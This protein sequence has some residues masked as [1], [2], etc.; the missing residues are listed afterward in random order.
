M[1]GVQL[2][3]L[4]LLWFYVLLNTVS[5]WRPVTSAW[6]KVCVGIVVSRFSTISVRK[7][8]HFC[9]QKS[10]DPQF[11]Q[12]MTKSYI[13]DLQVDW[14]LLDSEAKQKDC[15]CLFVPSGCFQQHT[16]FN[17][18]L[19]QIQWEQYGRRFKYT[20]GLTVYTACCQ[21]NSF[22]NLKLKL[23]REIV[24]ISPGLG[25]GGYFWPTNPWNLAHG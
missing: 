12:L 21:F 18:D 24:F 16:Y 22:F 4:L 6:A 5:G 1:G 25:L 20:S 11:D 17:S 3:L 9:L 19:V 23:N 8:F 14:S 15:H 7:L 10:R 2:L 13:S